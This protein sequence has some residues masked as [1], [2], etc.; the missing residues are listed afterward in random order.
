LRAFVDS[1]TGVADRRITV[2]GSAPGSARIHV[3]HTWT[4]ARGNGLR[5]PL[6]VYSADRPRSMLRRGQKRPRARGRAM[7]TRS[8][9]VGTVGRRRSTGMS[10]RARWDRHL[11]R[12]R[13]ARLAAL[14]GL[15]VAREHLGSLDRVTRIV[16]SAYPRRR[17]MFAISRKSRTARRSCCR[18]SLANGRTL[19]AWSTASRVFRSV[20]LWSWN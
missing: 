3:R 13:A 18:T 6:P 12:G 5:R 10:A 16:G 15:P 17:V 11:G 1:R 7:P 4:A 2:S 20:R 9:A 19:A 8:R 14:N